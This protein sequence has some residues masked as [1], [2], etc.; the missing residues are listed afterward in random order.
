MLPISVRS[1]NNS[2]NN[3]NSNHNNYDNKTE[4]KLLILHDYWW[5]FNLQCKLI[6]HCTS[7]V[8]EL[9]KDLFRCN[10]VYQVYFLPPQELPT[11]PRAISRRRRALVWWWIRLALRRQRDRRLYRGNCRASL[12][13]TGTLP[14]LDSFQ[15]N[16][17]NS[18]A[19]IRRRKKLVLVYLFTKC[20]GYM[21]F[22]FILIVT[23]K[24]IIESIQYPKIH[25]LPK[26][27]CLWPEDTCFIWIV[28]ICFLHLF[29]DACFFLLFSLSCFHSLTC[30]AFVYHLLKKMFSEHMWF[31][32]LIISGKWQNLYMMLPCPLG[33]IFC[34]EDIWCKYDQVIL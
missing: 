8:N 21:H 32:Y 34:H 2:Y 24:P 19:D 15:M 23:C 22:L 25:K 28:C 5:K 16:T 3:Y 26:R 29:N 10:V 18:A 27:F 11:G 17:L 6:I 31:R 9:I 13:E 14:L 12:S 33:W 20:F 30:Q 1:I 7:I 4:K